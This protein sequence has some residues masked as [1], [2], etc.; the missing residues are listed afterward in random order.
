MQARGE[1]ITVPRIS[2]GS[3]AKFDWYH[4]ISGNKEIGQPTNDLVPSKVA[5][6]LSTGRRDLT[7]R[8]DLELV[9]QS[10]DV[11][12]VSTKFHRYH[13]LE[14]PFRICFTVVWKMTLR[15]DDLGSL[16]ELV[17]HMPIGWIVSNRL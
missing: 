14:R 1:T 5:H 13:T 10:F 7:T 4:C 15:Y 8:K 17:Y 6:F 16:V 12:S 11:G 3:P 2:K 9:Q